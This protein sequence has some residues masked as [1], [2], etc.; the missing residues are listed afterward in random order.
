[1]KLAQPLLR[2]NLTKHDIELE[3]MTLCTIVQYEKSPT[4]GKR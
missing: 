2:D 1:M 4:V 3:I